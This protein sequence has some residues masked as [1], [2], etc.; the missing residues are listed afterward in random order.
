MTDPTDTRAEAAFRDA[1]AEH[2]DRFEPAPLR[3]VSGRPRIRRWVGVVAAASVLAVLG[4]TA[5]GV[6]LSR[7]DAGEPGDDTDQ[8]TAVE[9]LPDGWRYESYRDM[10]VEVPES[11]DYAQAP[12]GH[13]CASGTRP[14]ARQPYVDTSGRFDAHTLEGCIGPMP[15]RFKMTHV[16]F[17]DAGGSGKV[18]DGTTTDGG[19]TQIVKTVGVAQVR[20]FTDAAHLEEARRIVDSAEVVEVD[21][22][23]CAATSEIQAKKYIRPSVVFDI[24]DIADVDSISVCQY[25]LGDGMDPWLMAS[26]QLTGAT[27]DDVLAAIKATPAGGDPSTPDNCR[28][29]ET[30]GPGIVLRL[31]TGDRVHEMYGY[32]DHEN[33]SCTRNGFDDG[34][35]VRQLTRDACLPLYGG[36]VTFPGGPAWGCRAR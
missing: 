34:T 25:A 26:R 15:E 24:A 27:A 13:W 35:N 16:S 32:R 20:V 23:G 30:Y 1:F 11:W 36:R 33:R 5:V 19:W 8:T 18:E 7:D 10:Q 12:N 22:N 4:G 2:A 17:G 3:P 28:Y 9:G 14:P 21:S 29:A 31:K 6:V